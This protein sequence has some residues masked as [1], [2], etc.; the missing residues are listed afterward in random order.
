MTRASYK[1][2][3]AYIQGYADGTKANSQYVRQANARLEQIE[4]ILADL[5]NTKIPFEPPE[6]LAE[7]LIR[8][9][10]WL[11]RSRR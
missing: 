9:Q 2:N 10:D 3:P 7:P 6:E 11:N 8:I 5:L 1:S 4:T